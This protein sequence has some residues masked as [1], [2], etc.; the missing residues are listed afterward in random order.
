MVVQNP[1][2]AERL[3]AGRATVAV[4]GRNC[5][6]RAHADRLAVL[7]DGQAY[8][9]ALKA[10]LLRARHSI[11]L[12]GWDLDSRIR[13]D[14]EGEED[15]ANTLGALLRE[16]LRR[17]PGL[18]IHVLIWDTALI[19]YWSREFW[20]SLKYRLIAPR[21]LHFRLDDNHPLGASHHQ[22]IVAIDDSVAFVGGMDVTNGRWDTPE[23]N[24]DD[25]R[26]SD[27]LTPDYPPFHDVMLML[28]G[29]AAAALG[30]L[31]RERWRQARGQRLPPPPR[32]PKAWP[33]AVT[34][35]MEDVTVAIAR[36]APAW[37][38]GGE[39]REVE[40]LYLDM[41]A[42]A[43]RFVY[44]ENQFFAS[45][46]VGRAL[47]ARLNEPAAPEIVAV[48]CQEP[49]ALLERAAM[50][51]GRARLYARLRAADPRGRMRLFHPR[52]DGADVKVHSKLAIVDDR[53]LR[54]GSANLNNRSMGLDTECDV[55]VE[56]AGDARIEAAIR[57]LR[58]TLL[59]EHLGTAPERFAEAEAAYGGMLAAIDALNGGRRGLEPLAAAVP[60]DWSE[61]A[62]DIF[63]PDRPVE[64]I[65]AI[66]DAISGPRR[67]PL[68]EKVALL[69]IGLGMAAV[70]AA[71]WRWVLAPMLPLEAGRVIAA[72]AAFRDWPGAPAATVAGFVA[73][74]LVG[75][76]VTPLLIAAGMAF[77]VVGG[78][79]WGLAGALA[80]AIVLF[81]VGRLIGRD[82]VRRIAG[83]GMTRVIRAM[84]RRGVHVV[85]MLRLIPA[86]TYTVVNLVA[87]AARTRLG[88]YLL[89]TLLGMAPMAAALALFGDRV[90]AV[91]RMPTMW[92]IAVLAVLTA[93]LIAIQHSLARRVARGGPRLT[94][95]KP[96]RGEA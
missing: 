33:E 6:R 94:Q 40:R 75:V 72:A 46:A 34:P 66:E 90:A 56:S 96:D 82:R 13:L 12:V 15:G 71:L 9:S 19:Y 17:R 65:L 25:P 81:A 74:G 59:G 31:A 45:R 35:W 2:G 58:L 67:R 77:G 87:G 95:V 50:A 22:K 21:R 48:S 18:R 78:L 54:I 37:E 44:F 61:A 23:H 16:V 36:T 47:L 52:V 70:V 24:P 73:A 8:F 62:A 26:R 91:L 14:R 5:W 88:D 85:M 38:G 80:S 39:I 93:A 30:D 86:A 32:N 89:G 60:D 63:D 42:A 4:E 29:E 79:V 20:P 64:P 11:L 51:V 41:I 69:A 92:N 53:M 55:L 83:R 1:I 57:R 43:E 28:S 3:A 7:I 27:P 49:V 84:P 76:P 10:A 68:R